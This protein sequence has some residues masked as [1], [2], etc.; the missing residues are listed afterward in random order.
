MSIS[1]SI[2]ILTPRNLD[3]DLQRLFNRFFRFLKEGGIDE[4]EDASE[5]AP[6]GCVS[7]MTI[8]QSKGLE[9]PV[10]IVGS[11]DA[12]PR[13]QYTDL[14]DLLQ[15]KY[16]SKA[17]F[18]PLEQIKYYDFWRLFYTAFSR[19]Q[20]LL[21]LTCQE[22]IKGRRVPSTYFKPVYDQACPWRNDAFQPEYLTLETI[23]DVDL[24]NEYSFTS[25]IT[26]F[27]NCARQ[28]KFYRDLG[29]API[30]RNPI[31]FGTLVHQ[32]IED[33]HKAVL[34]GEEQKV[35]DQQ[36]S[37]WFHANYTHLSRQERLYLSSGGQQAALD[38]VLN[39]AHR[40]R[41]TW[42]RLRET[43]V[44]VSLVKDTYLLK[45]HVDLIRGENDTVEIVDFKSETKPDLVSEREKV[46]RY[47]R[48]L[49]VYAHI[50]EGRTGHK[51]SKMHLYY[52][53]EDD[54]NPYISFD[55]DVRSI[56]QTMEVFDGVVER[57]EN[58]DFEIASRPD[59]LCRNCDMK[60][61]CDAK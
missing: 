50:I 48:Q 44:E 8:H 15:R 60:A 21:L 3:R 54:S 34:H 9:F 4:Y 61:Y 19:A 1:I 13:K 53:G 17:P 58:K 5:Y 31:L 6:S 38:H 33:I 10:V 43:E 45:G 55:K 22:Q 12:V 51:I 57:I 56:D 52:T 49:E 16:Y 46:D 36:I 7:F 2:N 47:R 32:T 28:Y 25:H 35:T 42:D 24:K 23:K 27:E 30:R 18:E 11:M 59:R 37:D 26:V 29:F 14:D 41:R 40:E 39:Y 20:N